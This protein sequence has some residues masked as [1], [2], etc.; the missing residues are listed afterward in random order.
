MNTSVSTLLSDP[1]DIFHHSITDLESFSTSL[2]FDRHLPSVEAREEFLTQFLEEEEEPEIHHSDDQFQSSFAYDME[3]SIPAR[4]GTILD[5][6]LTEEEEDDD[7]LVNAALSKSN[8]HNNG[9]T[10]AKA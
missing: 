5:L 4:L 6:D 10:T 1:Q 3:S 9:A 8:H 7:D 2:D